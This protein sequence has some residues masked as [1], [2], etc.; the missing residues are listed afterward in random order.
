MRPPAFLPLLSAAAGISTFAIM[1]ALMKRASMLSG[2]YAALLW[3]SAI[4]AVLALAIW[5]L[6][7]GGPW[8][9]RRRLM[10]HAAR[11]AVT[12]CMAFTFFWGLVRTPMAV[13][14]AL[15]FIAPII[16]LFMTALFLGEPV[17]R[18]ALVASALGLAGVAVIGAGRLSGGLGS[19]SGIGMLAVLGSAVL[20]AANLVM[21]RH[22]AQLAAPAEIAFFQSLFMAVL[23]GLASLLPAVRAYAMPVDTAWSDIAGGAVLA[24]ISLMLL[25]WGWARAPANRLLPVEY[26]AFLWSALMGYLWFGERLGAATLVGVVLIVAGCWHGTMRGAGGASKRAEEAPHIE[27]TAL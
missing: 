11:A 26:S 20:Y 9:D 1:D 17:T 27:Q 13:G 2:V 22:Q 19:E 4:G 18:R 10:L 15:S 16:A 6:V 14:M 25:S 3:R 7:T 23:L 8:P 12:C 21:Q 24:T 5:R